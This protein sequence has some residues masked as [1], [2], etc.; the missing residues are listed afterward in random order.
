MFRFVLAICVAT[1]ALGAD[2]AALRL[3]ESAEV[4]REIMGTPDRGIPQDLLEKA[5]CAVIIPGMKKGAFIVGAK[6]GRGFMSCRT[7]RVGWSA[8][9]AVRV[10]GGSLGFQIGGSETD[11]V[12]LVLNERGAEKLLRSKFTLGGDASVAAGPVGR[13]SSAETDA[14]L[15]AEILSWSRSRGAFA[16]ISLRGAT[17]RPDHDANAELYGKK[18]EN[19][20]IIA[21][22]VPAPEAAKSLLDILNRYSSRK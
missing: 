4:M 1:A 16:G 10:E 8:P 6:Y 22:T 2:T 14:Y 17:L 18:L 7:G 13:T 20:D 11:V 9:A 19:R 21:G 3:E 12:M 5:Q 15:R